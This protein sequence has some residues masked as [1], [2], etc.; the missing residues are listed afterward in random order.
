MCKNNTLALSGPFRIE[1]CAECGNLSVHLGPITVRVDKKALKSLH[2][3]SG[4][5]L[6]ALEGV[7][8]TPPH[9]IPLSR[10]EFN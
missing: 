10:D 3:I 9:S 1:G 4:D 8:I 2:R 5:A 7:V 6:S